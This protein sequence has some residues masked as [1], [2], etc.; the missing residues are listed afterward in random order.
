MSE[1]PNRA[2]DAAEHAPR[3]SGQSD[4]AL[5]P[6]RR[7]VPRT[8]REIRDWFA[9]DPVDP[10][11][12]AV[13]RRLRN[14]SMLSMSLTLVIL[15]IGP[16]PNTLTLTPLVAIAGLAVPGLARNRWYWLLLTGLVTI[17][18][19]SRPWLALDNH[20]WLQLYWF[21]ALLLTRFAVDADRAL[22]RSARL[23]VGLAFLF[24]VTWKIIAPEF[25]SGA[26]FDY[27]FAIDRRL[28]DV[29]AAVGVQD[30]ELTNSNRAT[31][32]AWRR[33]GTTPEPRDFVVNEQL[34][35]WTPVMAWLTIIVE[36]AVAV[37]FLAPL[38]ARLA[39]IRDVSMLVFVLAT[40]PLAPVLGFGRLLLV[41]SAMQST[42]KP[43]VRAVVYV[44]AFAA[45]SL[46]SQ[47]G[48]ALDW[49]S[50]LFDV[51]TDADV[52]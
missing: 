8:L 12:D 27:T 21:L 46:L 14:A 20:H 47:R 9:D 45:L 24:A 25:L 36:G 7:T 33:P 43:R 17:G 3:R 4:D 26:F 5:T 18:T 34:A 42:L 31:V 19:L 40:Y 49:L 15:L 1:T 6:A 35:P 23:L 16:P 28:G 37:S 30:P 29:A 32:T 38:A 52:P 48:V 11:E 41:M 44:G 50:D 10:F 2:S 39:W 13:D 51:V 22:A